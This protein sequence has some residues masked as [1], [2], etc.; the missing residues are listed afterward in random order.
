MTTIAT[1]PRSAALV[2][3]FAAIVGERYALVD[4]QDVEPYLVEQRDLWH[5]KALCVLRP[6]STAEVS[7]IMKLCHE[8]KTP[9]VPQGG[10]TGLVGGQ[11]PDESGTQVILSL[12]RMDKVREIDKASNTMTVEAGLTLI[13]VQEAADAADRLFP[14]SLASEGS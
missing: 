9:V 12:N 5:G 7:A 3:R 1:L 6:A 11:S 13:R 10:N 14:L 2:S 4:A 8:T